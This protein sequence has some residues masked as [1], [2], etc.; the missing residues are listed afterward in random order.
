MMHTPGVNVMIALN[1]TQWP[2]R[3]FV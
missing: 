2:F 1:V 3:L